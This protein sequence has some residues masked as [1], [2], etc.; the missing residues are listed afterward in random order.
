MKIRNV[1]ILLLF[2][3]VL[4]GFRKIPEET[5]QTVISLRQTGLS[6]PKISK[7]TGISS[8][9]VYSICNPEVKKRLD[10]DYAKR[11][12]DRI[13]IYKSRNK[14]KFSNNRK[15]YYLN[16]LE[17]ERK[18]HSIWC[19]ENK[20]K[21][22]GYTRKRDFYKNKAILLL[23]SLH[24]QQIDAFYTSALRLTELTGIKH[25]V[26]HIVPLKGKDVTGLHVPWN[27]QIL[28]AIDNRKKGNR[29][30]N[31]ERADFTFVPGGISGM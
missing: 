31:R 11:H 24:L 23:S 7:E 17:K 9:H 20:A 28:T 29:I 25:E 30:I 2:R 19:K 1:L 3:E 14:E 16:N 4:V 15:L 18:N 21:C 10:K 8:S 13:K 12:K 26:D 5:R 6:Y 22:A 27:L